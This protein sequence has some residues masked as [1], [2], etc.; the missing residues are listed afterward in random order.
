MKKKSYT[1]TLSLLAL[2]LSLSIS[3]YAQ[4]FTDGLNLINK[5]K[6]NAAFDYFNT[7]LSAD[8]KNAEIYYRLGDISFLQGKNDAAKDFYNKGIAANANYPQN[9]IGIAKTFLAKKDTASAKGY[10]EKALAV[11]DIKPNSINLDIAEAYINTGMDIKYAINLINDAMKPDKKNPNARKNSYAYYLLGSA[12]A[13]LNNGSEAI[14]NFE[15]AIDYDPKSIKARV[16]AASL[17]TDIKNYEEAKGYFLKAITMDS[18]SALA[19]KEFSNLFY[20]ISQNDK[21]LSN[22]DIMTCYAKAIHYQEVYIYNSEKSPSN[23]YRYATL[24]YLMQD[25]QK[26]VG[27]INDYLTLEAKSYGMFRLLAYSE[28]ELKDDNACKAAF[29]KYFAIADS[30][31]TIASDYER[32][33]KTLYNL[34]D[35]EGAAN[36]YK[37][38]IQADTSMAYLYGNIAEIYL[39]KKNFKEAAENYELKIAKTGKGGFMDF[40][41]MGQSYYILKNYEKADTA[42]ASASLLLPEEPGAYLFR[43]RCKSKIDTTS[44]VL[45]IPFYEKTIEKSVGNSTKYKRLLIESYD[46]IARYYIEKEE[47]S[48]SKT[49]WEKLIEV[50][51]ENENAKTVLSSPQMKKIK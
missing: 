49:Y 5:E 21:S 2:F 22:Q 44:L 29:E 12:Y 28:Y 27:I 16:G 51:P 45:A 50:D 8:A 10:I 43:A 37:K 7:K 13:Q 40:F 14:K 42:F 11:P 33:G 18:T 23:L 39:K 4:N 17:Y 35:K 1:Q 19:N 3:A 30:S 26:T 41:N 38:C 9:Y 34:D 32:Y 31:Q 6:Y 20:Q 25:Y 46:S 48:K 36:S 15:L 47:Y 24:A